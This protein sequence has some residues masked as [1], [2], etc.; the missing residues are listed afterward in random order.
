MGVFT[1]SICIPGDRPDEVRRALERWLHMRG[2]KI[3]QEPPLFDLDI[4][5]ERSAFVVW[6]ES[7]TVLFFSQWEE[8]RRLIRELQRDLSPLLYLWVYDSDVWGWDLFG[9]G[10]FLSSF[11]SDPR[12][13]TSFSEEDS[14]EARPAADPELLCRSLGLGAGKAAEVRAVQ[15]KSAFFKEEICGELCELFGLDPALA[16]YD[17]LE[18]GNLGHRLEGWRS[19]QWMYF[20]YDAAVATFE[21]E[22]DVH[23]L[24]LDEARQLSVYG[25]RP[26]EISPEL[27]AEMEDIRRRARR[28]LLIL[29]PISWLASGWRRARQ[30]LATASGGRR[31]EDLQPVVAGSPISVRPT[32]T[33]TRHQ[34]SNRRHSVRLL[35]PQGVEP[36][37]VSGKPA[38]VFSFRSGALVVTCTAR[39]LRH[40]G[41]VLRPPSRSTVERDERYTAGELPAR[42]LLFR[43]PASRFTPSQEARFLALHVVQTFR[44]LYVFLYR[45]EREASADDEAA[46]RAAVESFR[47]EEDGRRPR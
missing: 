17:D 14:H 3:S 5:S 13:F 32:E 47:A 43:M 29:R 30:L 44:A 11:C 28:N 18:T 15:K 36:I 19:A 22:P 33:A 21:G 9:E 23:A 4:E 31:R 46:I 37:A 8:E 12:D 2:F 27:L 40:L 1:N 20:H 42:H 45:F 10:G 16:S 26:V 24:E 38:S 7:W 39:R 34:V 6:N 35:L 41:E 25:P